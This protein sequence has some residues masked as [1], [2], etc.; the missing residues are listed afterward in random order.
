MSPETTSRR[1]AAAQ[2]RGRRTGLLVLA[3]VAAAGL[4]VAAVAI[5]AAG[6]RRGAA[7]ATAPAAS[8]S[9]QASDSTPLWRRA[10]YFTVGFDKTLKADLLDALES[11]PGLVVFGGSRA[12]R[13]EPSE[14][15]RRTGLSA[16]N[17][18]VQC[19]RPEDAW[20][21]TRHLVRRSP[22]TRL[23]CVFALQ[24]RTFRD[25]QMRAGL[26]YDRRLARAF[27]NDLVAA[28]KATL[29]TPSKRDALG[30]NRYT[31][32][33]YMTRNRY[34]IG[35]ERPGYR[36]VRQIDLSIERLLP[37]HTGEALAP[38]ARSRAYFERTVRLY[39]RRGVTPLVILMPIQPRALRAFRQ[40]GFQR[41]LDDFTAYLE[42]AQ[43][44]CRFRVLDFTDVAAFGGSPT[45]FYDAVHPTRENTRR[46]IAR[47]VELAPECFE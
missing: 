40:A 9:A 24:A 42:D 44:R 37:N 46:I 20:A 26:L 4:L 2:K 6:G 14:I 12:M 35:R 39:N 31:A 22:R 23:R 45:E 17:C 7:D 8:V 32:R 47:A 10:S 27:P 16:F 29:G 25:D 11:P 41:Q 3:A 36:F 13:F 15:R 5:A 1:A 18:A 19:F 28:Q 21:F 30:E 34:D 38:D 43:G 33:G